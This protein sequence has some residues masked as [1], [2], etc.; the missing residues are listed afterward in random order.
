[1]NGSAQQKSLSRE[2]LTNHAIASVLEA[3]LLFLAGVFA[4]VL[5][6]RLRTPI[7]VPGHHGI[8]F[9][10][11]ILAARLSSK[12][13]WAASISALGIG[14]FI[15]FPV[16]GF[17]DPM[18]GFNYMLPCFVLD[19]AYLAIPTSKFKN[20]FLALAAGLGYL[21]IPLSRIVITFSTGY[22]Y[23]SFLKHGFVTPLFSFFVF[24]A[25]GGFLG[26]GLYFVIKKV[27]RKG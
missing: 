27:F 5:H 14:V 2:F 6:E 8:E 20:V 9:M 22:P 11:V 19:L 13:K 25:M 26:A 3:V 16:L 7:N 15:L 12:M 18:M 10:G 4:I 21:M 23:S 17:K 1:M 24:G